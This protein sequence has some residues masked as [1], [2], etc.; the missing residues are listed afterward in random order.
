MSSFFYEIFWRESV[1][2]PFFVLWYLMTVPPIT[3][4]LILI[5]EGLCA[6]LLLQRSGVLKSRGAWVLSILLLTLALGLR[7][8]TQ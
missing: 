3:V 7:A 4:I 2:R 5:I 6:L 1:L 8:A